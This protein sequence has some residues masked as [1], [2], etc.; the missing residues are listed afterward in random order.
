MFPE[1]LEKPILLIRGQKVM[2]DRHLAELY[3]VKLIAL[4]QQ[5]KRNIE[6]FPP[7]FMLQLS[8]EETAALVSHNVIPSRRSPGG[9]LPYAFT[10]EG[11]AMLSG[12]LRSK[13]A[14]D[15]NIAIMRTFVRLLDP[16]K[17]GSEN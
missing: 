6:R 11:A 7:D 4:R 2:L 14:I 5:M 12:V 8:V 17:Q 3:G 15:A 1:C 9:A 10:Q 16:Q 13:R